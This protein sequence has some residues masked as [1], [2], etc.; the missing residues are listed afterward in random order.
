MVIGGRH[1]GKVA[2]ITE[3]KVMAGSVP[4]R[5]FLEDT[6]TSEQFE[7]IEDYVFMVGRETPAVAEWGIEQ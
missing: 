6:E 3:I 2:K 4:N 5:V 7:T 1:S